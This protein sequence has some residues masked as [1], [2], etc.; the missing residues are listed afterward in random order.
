MAM[1]R[2]DKRCMMKNKIKQSRGIILRPQDEDGNQ[3]LLTSSDTSGNALYSQ[4]REI[5]TVARAKAYSAVNFAMVEAYWQVGR[6]I[7]EKQ[8]GEKR[9]DYGAGLIKHELIH[10]V[11]GFQL[12]YFI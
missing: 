9:A 8:G 6:L 1:G 11:V 12:Y 7:V 5:L 2:Y 10:C 4:I 3:I